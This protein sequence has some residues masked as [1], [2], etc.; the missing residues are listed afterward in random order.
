MNKKRC[1]RLAAI[2]LIG[3]V[4]GG[5]MSSV[6]TE[7]TT[8]NTGPAAPA[9]EIIKQWKLLGGGHWDYLALDATGR[10]L[11]ITRIDHIDVVDTA[12]GRLLGVI[13]DMNWVH[14]VA[15]AEDLNRGYASNGKGDSVTVF[16]LKTLKVEKIAPVSGR[17]PDAILYDP[18]FKHVFTFNGRSKDVTVLDAASLAI[19]ATLPV[20][21]KPEFA[22]DDGAGQIFVN[23]ESD[24]GKIVAI[25]ARTLTI[26]ATWSLPGCTEPSGLAIDK[27]HRRLFSVCG[28]GVMV[29]TDAD[30]GRQVAT[31][32][33]GAGPDAAAFDPSR[34]LVFSSNID[35]TLNVIHQASADRYTPVQ[36]VKTAFGAR[37]MALDPLLGRIYLVTSQ[38]GPM[39]AATAAEPI[40]HPTPIPG[41]LRVL[42]VGTH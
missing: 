22:V 11:F 19:V 2:L 5:P 7:S 24:A 37:T 34:G 29:V 14:G 3:Y 32:K 6:A 27:K 8:M 26:K 41:S 20:P 18:L 39:P 38:F 9:L 25:D 40:P 35:G 33:I 36:N 13:P 31:V 21:D 17:N 10:Q 42:V 1:G 4:A 12:S 15:L 16:N 23:I 28:A 30:N